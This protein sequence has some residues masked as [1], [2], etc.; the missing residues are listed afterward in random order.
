MS[1]DLALTERC[2]FMDR[3][4]DEVARE[5]RG[6]V[7]EE[8]HRLVQVHGLPGSA[9]AIERACLPVSVSSSQADDLGALDWGRPQSQAELAQRQ[10]RER[11]P[12]QRL[13]RW[14]ATLTVGICGFLGTSFV[15]CL[16]GLL[17]LRNASPTAALVN[18]TH[19]VIMSTLLLGMVCRLI[20]EI[21]EIRLFAR[22]EILEAF[23]PANPTRQQVRLWSAL[24]RL[25]AYLAAC[26]A[27]EVGLLQ[28]DVEALE[29]ALEKAETEDEEPLDSVDLG[30]ALSVEPMGTSSLSDVNR[31]K[32]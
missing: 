5:R 11:A 19:I 16:F 12:V 14:C 28:G 2:A 18:T 6:L 30:R 7:P 10:E 17:F 8:A 25:R 27:S 9:S 13:S 21:C 3:L 15:A 32:P 24:P 31:V 4:S 26:H 20:Q 29:A 23:N 22:R 1:V